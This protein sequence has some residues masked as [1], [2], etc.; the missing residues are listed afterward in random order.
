[1][2][3]GRRFRKHRVRQPTSSGSAVSSPSESEPNTGAVPPAPRKMGSPQWWWPLA[4]GVAYG[5]IIR[6]IFSGEAHGPYTAMMDSF[7]LLVPILV[8]A[9]TVMLAE[10]I[11]RR[12]WS[13]YFWAAAGANALFVMGTLALSIEGVICCVLAVPL[14]ALLGGFG[15]L[16]TGMLFRF[17]K[18]PRQAVYGFAVLPLILGGFEQNLALPNTIITVQRSLHIAAPP[19]NVWRQLLSA[20]TIQPAEMSDGFMYRIGVPI[21]LSA[22]TEEL[23]GQ[24][25]RH[26]TM[27]K[28]IHFDQVA[29]DWQTNRRV[30]WTYRFTNDSFPAGALDDHVRIGGQY[31]DVIDTEYSIEEKPG[32]SL[33]GVTMRYRVSTN[34]NWYVRP[35]AAFLASNFEETALKFYAR[36]AES[37]SLTAGP[38]SLHTALRH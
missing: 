7:T 10:R 15:G 21:P 4:A 26:I 20:Q 17:Y 1:L 24:L 19:A 33:L 27:G 18:Y 9:I 2:E 8:G 34:F 3:R 25:V 36:R 6:L 35:I 22:T 29:A 5:I 31:F 23:G 32:G 11:A 12:S 16:L 13:Y 30:L 38:N 37:D 14:F 28:N